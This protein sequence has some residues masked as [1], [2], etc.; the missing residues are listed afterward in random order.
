MWRMLRSTFLKSLLVIALLLAQQGVVTHVISHVLEEQSQDQSLPHDRHCDICEIYAQ[1]SG[2]IGSSSIE[3]DFASAFQET[4]ATL[5]GS[6]RS[7]TF[8]AFAARAPPR[9]A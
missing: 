3:F 5:L 4:F 8:G 7:V 9:F 1:I 6:C 2:A